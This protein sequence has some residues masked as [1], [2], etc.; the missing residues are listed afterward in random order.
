[1]F[2]I[3]ITCLQFGL[4]SM[5]YTNLPLG[6]L[7]YLFIHIMEHIF[8]KYKTESQ[9]LQSYH[10]WLGL[11]QGRTICSAV[12]RISWTIHF[13]ELKKKM[14]QSFQSWSEWSPD[15][16]CSRILMNMNCLVL[17]QKPFLA[18]WHWK[19]WREKLG[20]LH[21]WQDSLLLIFAPSLHHPTH[22]TIIRH[23]G[24]KL[25]L[26]FLL[27]KAGIKLS[28]W[29]SMVVRYPVLLLYALR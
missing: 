29:D 5:M 27:C 25:L 23:F 24:L 10:W 9:A 19:V 21:T 22:P 7:Q 8:P 12:F 20:V 14:M 18:N 15:S 17:L 1:M 2:I 3:A 13:M 6:L 28:C 4:M 26:F 11:Y 16:T